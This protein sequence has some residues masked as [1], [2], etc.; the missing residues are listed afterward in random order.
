MSDF[1][2]TPIITAKKLRGCYLLWKDGRVVYVGQSTNIM[3]RVG[4]HL[5]NPL[6]SFDGFCYT[7]ISGD[8]NEAEAELIVKHQPTINSSMPINNKYATT[9]Q[10]RRKFDIDGWKFKKIKN[11][12]VYVWKDCCE[13]E[14]FKKLTD[15]NGWTI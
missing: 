15:L 6:K 7:L 3:A 13:V 14:Q 4:F 11:N 2:F 5:T 8:L 1:D 10:L 9:L 12:I